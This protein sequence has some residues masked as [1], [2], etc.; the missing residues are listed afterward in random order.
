MTVLEEEVLLVCI[1]DHDDYD[2]RNK[3][4]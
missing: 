3:G 1:C 4:C 2:A